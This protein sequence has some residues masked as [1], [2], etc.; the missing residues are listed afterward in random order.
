MDF[1]EQVRQAGFP[2][3]TRVEVVDTLEGRVYRVTSGEGASGLELLATPDALQMYGE[4]PVTAL[5]L[6]RLRERAGEGLPPA[7]AS[8]S[9]AREVFVGD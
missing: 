9:Y 8:G 5:V 3:G 7:T 2:A 1:Q 4:G 6:G